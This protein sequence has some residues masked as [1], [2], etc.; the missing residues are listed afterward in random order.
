MNI[1]AICGKENIDILELINGW[2]WG[3][4][5]AP[6]PLPGMQGWQAAAFRISGDKAY[7]SGCG[8]YGA[9]DTLCDDAG[10]HYFKECYIEGSIDFIFGNG[11]SMYKV[12]YPYFSLFILLLIIYI[13]LLITLK[14]YFNYN[15]FFT[16]YSLVN[17][18]LLSF[19]EMEGCILIYNM[20]KWVKLRNKNYRKKKV[21]TYVKLWPHIY[22]IVSI[23]FQT[24][25]G[26]T[27][28]KY[29]LFF[30]FLKKEVNYKDE[31]LTMDS[32]FWK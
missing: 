2:R 18:K 1:S 28:L 32:C 31:N 4:N 12:R 3:Q 9:Q 29:C 19:V 21:G 13:F 8:F 14:F 30:F 7:F 24:V 27:F 11:R 23:K 25:K 26:L 17:T 20:N 5:T 16:K 10:R 6:A 22:Y 15:N